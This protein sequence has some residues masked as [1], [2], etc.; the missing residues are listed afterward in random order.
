[1]T[2]KINFFEVILFLS[3]PSIKTSVVNCYPCAAWSGFYVMPIWKWFI[4]NMRS[5][6]GFCWP[7]IMVWPWLWTKIVLCVWVSIVPPMLI[8]P[9]LH[10]VIMVSV[11]PPP[12]VSVII[13]ESVWTPRLPTRE[14]H[15]NVFI[16]VPIIISTVNYTQCIKE[17][18]CRVCIIDIA[19]VILDNKIIFQVI[20]MI[21]NVHRFCC[22]TG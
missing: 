14:N 19:D 4:I 1:M 7:Y 13:E 8:F 16:N 22:N 15:R 11:P 17:Q 3:S 12:P 6:C 20:G 18:C 9:I 21:G 10:M 2:P 5:C